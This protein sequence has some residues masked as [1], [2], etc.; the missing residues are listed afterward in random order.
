MSVKTQ[1]LLSK[2]QYQ[3]WE[4]DDTMKKLHKEF[5]K[6]EQGVT[7]PDNFKAEAEKL[8]Y[9]PTSGIIKTL[10][11]PQPKFGNVV[12]D[13]GKFHKPTKQEVITNNHIDNYKR[14]QKRPPAQA[15]H[16]K[17]EKLKAL[18]DF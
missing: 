9:K 6:F 4:K 15:G 10:S 8:G 1:T 18:Q 14:Y 7:G 3:P 13:L 11:D 2:S 17:N 12:K 16:C 5:K